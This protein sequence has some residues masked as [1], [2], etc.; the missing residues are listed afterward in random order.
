MELKIVYL[1]EN[2]ELRPPRGVKRKEKIEFDEKTCF[3]D[4]SSF[5]DF[6]F[7]R[8][9]A[10]SLNDEMSKKHFVSSNS[11]F[12][13]RLTPLGGLNSKFSFGYT[14]FELCTTKSRTGPR[15]ARTSLRSAAAKLEK[16]IDFSFL[17]V[18]RSSK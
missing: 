12:S 14:Y 9:K 10:K 8:K 6:A 18:V 11:I 5:N 13:L 15:F 16:K 2:F 4:I 17:N 7:S 3:F 1:K